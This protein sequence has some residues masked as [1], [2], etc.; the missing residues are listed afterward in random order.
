VL[1]RQ[2]PLQRQQQHPAL[3]QLHSWQ[4]LHSRALLAVLLQQARPLALAEVATAEATAGPRAA[5]C[6]LAAV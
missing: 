4:R 5:A 1:P 3:R 6:E 2:A